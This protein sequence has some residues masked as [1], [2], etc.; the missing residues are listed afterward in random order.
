MSE[1]G[2]R[3]FEKSAPPLT[4]D[5]P[6]CGWHS[7]NVLLGDTSLLPFTPRGSRACA[8]AG[9]RPIFLFTIRGRVTL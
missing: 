4:R 9:F 1:K 3:G 6:Y 2:R 7:W 8:P 5:S